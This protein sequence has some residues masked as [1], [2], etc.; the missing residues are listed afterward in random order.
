MAYPDVEK[1]IKIKVLDGVDSILCYSAAKT[2][3]Y[4]CLAGSRKYNR[5]VIIRVQ[6]TALN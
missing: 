5:S 4:I 3:G 6:D 1:L 2:Y